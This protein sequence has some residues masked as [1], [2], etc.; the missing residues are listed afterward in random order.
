MQ[1]VA[2]E[3]GGTVRILDDSAGW[4]GRCLPPSRLSY[5][6][7]CWL[8]FLLFADKCTIID[9]N[10]LLYCKLIEGR[11]MIYS[12]LSSQRELGALHTVGTQ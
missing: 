1:R 7:H 10:L 11:A 8:S 2:A 12:P 9:M 3:K 4:P 6:N 5:V